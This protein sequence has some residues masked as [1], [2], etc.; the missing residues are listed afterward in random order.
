[1]TTSGTPLRDI[2]SE[3]VERIGKYESIDEESSKRTEEGIC[4]RGTHDERGDDA[5]T[6]RGAK[7]ISP[8]FPPLRHR[9]LA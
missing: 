9:T 8:R 6:M 2:E 4:H 3:N 7:A 1:M 5:R